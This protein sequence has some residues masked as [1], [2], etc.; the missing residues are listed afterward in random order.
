MARDIRDGKEEIAELLARTLRRLFLRRGYR[1]SELVEFFIRLV[2]NR[3]HAWPI[4]ADRGRA[5]LK[6]DRA[7]QRRER[8]RH[9]IEAGAGADADAFGLLRLLDPPPHVG[10]EEVLAVGVAEHMGM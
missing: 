3:R 6:L 10:R 9:V 7:R 4:E 2:E 5:L 8:K 1:R